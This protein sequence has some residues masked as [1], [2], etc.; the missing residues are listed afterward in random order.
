MEQIRQVLGSFQILAFR[1]STLYYWFVLHSD[2]PRQQESHL[3]CPVDKPLATLKCT[4][5]VEA[6]TLGSGVD[7]VEW[8]R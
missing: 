7:M 6:G 1:P 8:L 5:G 4:A 2:F 3:V